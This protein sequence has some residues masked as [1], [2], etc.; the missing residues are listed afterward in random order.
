M[1]AI[2]Q[3][4]VRPTPGLV[5]AAVFDP[6]EV[7]GPIARTAEDAALLLAGMCGHDPGRPLA[8]PDQERSRYHEEEEPR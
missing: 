7:V 4:R 6:I 8:R 1:S 5:P 3:D 2:H